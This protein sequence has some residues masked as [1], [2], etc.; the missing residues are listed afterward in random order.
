MATQSEG[1]KQGS[2]FKVQEGKWP[3]ELENWTVVLT[4]AE[5]ATVLMAL[6]ALLGCHSRDEVL[7][8]KR[9]NRHLAL[10]RKFGALLDEEGK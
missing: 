10:A 1:G 6:G 8:K 7:D 4:A 9:L 2:G 3:I 5:R